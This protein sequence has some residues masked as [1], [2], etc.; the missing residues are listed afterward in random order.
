MSLIELQQVSKTFLDGYTEVKAVREVNLLLEKGEFTALAGPSGS[1]KTTLLNM[2][3]GLEM[4]SSGRIYFDGQELSSL[5]EK[6]R[7]S[8]RRRRVGFIFQTFSLIPVFSA[9]ENVELSLALL[10]VSPSEMNRRSMELLD[11]VGI[12]DMAHRRPAQLSGGQQQRVAIARALIK[13]PEI[14]LADE[15]TANLDSDT[16]AEILNLMSQLN[17]VSKIT[18]LF[19][20]HDQKVM[21][22]AKRLIILQD[23]RVILDEKRTADE[24]PKRSNES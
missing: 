16:G 12:A 13:D 9:M 5:S 24:K 1:G 20:T 23:G 10:G 15:P 7:T 8:L 18:F 4:P 14:V 19:S 11:R 6:E 3:G 2:I 21:E 22:C 17:R